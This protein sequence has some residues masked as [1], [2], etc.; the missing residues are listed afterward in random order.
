MWTKTK[1]TAKKLIKNLVTYGCMVIVAATLLDF[2]LYT[3]SYK[4]I[5]AVQLPHSCPVATTTQAITTAKIAPVQIKVGKV[6][7]V[8][9]YNSVESQTDGS[10]CIAADNSNVCERHAKGECIVALNGVKFGTKLLIEKIGTCTV[11]DRT[12]TKHN[13]TIDLFMGDDVARATNFG[14][15]HLAYTIID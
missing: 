6:A 2:A 11:A 8:T 3:A 12:A 4:A 13:G 9:A 10:P 1:A 15:Q 14:V 5:M 7:R